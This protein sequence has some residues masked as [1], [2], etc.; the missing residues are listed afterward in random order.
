M[1]NL[2]AT[3][4]LVSSRYADRYGNPFILTKGQTEIFDCIAKRLYPRVLCRCFTRY[5]KSETVGLAVLTRITTYPEKWA[6]VAP[7]NKKAGIIM[8]VI[9]QHIFDN[10]YT[11]GKFEIS[12]NENLDRIR[13]ERSKERL[14]FKISNNRIGEVFIISSEGKRTRDV[15]DAL[16]GF[17]APNVIID[18]SSL[19]DDRQ[20]AG[21]KR[22]LGDET[23]NLLFEIGNPFRRNHFL[24]SARNPLYHQINIDWKQGVEEGR[25]K[26]EY[27]EEM[28]KEAGFDILYENEFP[29]EDA[30]DSKSYV[31]LITEVDLDRAFL[32]D[33]DLFGE[34]RLGVD[35]A[36]GGKNFSVIVL[37][38]NNG[39]KV[40]LREQ[41][42]DTMA[43]V[44]IILQ[45]M[46]KY[47]IPIDSVFIDTVGIG[48][49]VYDRL[50]EVKNLDN[51]A[52]N[53][54]NFGEKPSDEENFMNL[55]AEC[56]WQTA[57]WI[58]NGAKLKK[59]VNWNEFL[60][61]KYK[62][63][64]DRKVKIMPKEEMLKQGIQSPDTA[65]ALALCFA[66]SQNTANWRQ[67]EHFAINETNFYKDNLE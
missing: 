14:T 18:E 12:G 28:R 7:S 4:Q 8:G 1:S 66:K 9:I 17:G 38:G 3:Q 31:S 49:G 5:G 39:A 19:I 20:Y 11:L 10:E 37:K 50:C 40:L 67:Q 41:L 21:I 52:A 36:G 55:R 29:A 64:S 61:I 63:Q 35:V 48:R 56:Y 53:S 59:D 51:I 2:S 25:I 58:R 32:D 23:D 22:M 30:I 15:M 34:L 26:K 44:G 16:M 43:L 6:I 33:F 60:D 24:R 62:I 65:D 46:A 54:V 13:R 47:N 57:D 45:L 42:S 27:V